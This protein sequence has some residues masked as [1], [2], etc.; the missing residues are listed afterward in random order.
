VH[1]FQRQVDEGGSAYSSLAAGRNGTQSE[2]LIFLLKEGI[3]E[4]AHNGIK[5]AL[6][7]L[8]W[9][10]QGQN[11]MEFILPSERIY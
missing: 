4:N 2:G 3:G 8:A 5:V 10:T 6:F 1:P 11:W 9:A 7:N